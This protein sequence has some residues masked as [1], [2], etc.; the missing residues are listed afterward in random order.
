MPDQDNPGRRL[1]YRM[2]CDICHAAKIK[3]GSQKPSCRRC[4]VKK[5][6][7]VYS[8]SHRK[9]R[10]REKRKAPDDGV[11]TEYSQSLPEPIQTEAPD[12][13]T[14]PS[15]NFD[16][17][18]TTEPSETSSTQ[19]AGATD[20]LAFTTDFTPFELDNN[21]GF[22]TDMLCSL[23]EPTIAEDVEPAMEISTGQVENTI[24]TSYDGDF[25]LSPEM[26]DSSDQ[27]LFRF[28]DTQTLLQQHDKTDF[29]S[30]VGNIPSFDQTL[31]NDLEFLRNVQMDDESHDQRRNTASANR[32]PTYPSPND[33][34]PAWCE[35]ADGGRR[36][37]GRSN[38]ECFPALLSRI[39]C[40]KTKQ[41]S[42][43]QIPLSSVLVIERETNEGLSRLHRCKNCGQDSMVFLFAMVSVRIVL[44]LIQKTVHDEFM[45]VNRKTNQSSGVGRS[46]GVGEHDS[47]SL[48]IGNF[49]VPARARRRYLREV[50]QARFSKFLVLVE[51]REKQVDGVGHQD[52][53]AEGAS[54]LMLNI[55][56]DLKTILGR[57]ELWSSKD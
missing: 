45:T 50:L 21:F 20:S 52:C 8:V 10:P 18:A 25:L 30:T 13:W 9:G 11:T 27:M 1:K 54:T 31:D 17:P 53:F 41:K 7:C 51:E 3:C 5:L 37:P 49:K 6:D 36:D 43:R 47:S 19:H 16:P 4:S 34:F 22:S 29:T 57:V 44:D 35:L 24:D 2:S 32:N 38:C 28:I 46:R 23:D 40:L 48:Y 12:A 15:T 39:R 55:A 33:D 26:L 56:R 14:P 42:R